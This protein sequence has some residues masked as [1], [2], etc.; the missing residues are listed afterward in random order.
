MSIEPLTITKTV[1]R[2]DDFLSWQRTK[3]LELRPYF[4]RGNVWDLNTKSY[5]ID[6]IIRGFPVPIIFLQTESNPS[7]LAATRRVVDGQQRLRTVLGFIDRDCLPDFD[8]ARDDFKIRKIHSKAYP[9]KRF[10]ELPTDVRQRILEAEFSVHILPGSTSN[11]RLLEL[12]ARLNSSGFALEKQELRNAAFHGAFKQLA[13]DLA[14]EITDQLLDWKIFH[15]QA[16]ARMK[17]VEL[18][19]ELLLLLMDPNNENILGKS[20]EVLDKA[21]ETHDDVVP[22]SDGLEKT[23]RKVIASLTPLYQ[24]PDLGAFCNQSWFYALFA[25]CYD[26]ISRHSGPKLN[27]DAARSAL[28]KLAAQLA[29]DQIDPAL[30]K[31]LRGASTDTANRLKRFEF[32]RS[33][34]G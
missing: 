33:A 23:F 34:F 18:V 10:R 5:F 26:R 14:F 21:Y 12:F 32:V 6:S 8:D 19:S 17:E 28:I 29:S 30:L 31:A 9:N 11:G 22:N 13:Y 1:Y 20:Q 27:S 2:V 3:Q 25:A 24:G 7:S 16:V 15:R 4:Q